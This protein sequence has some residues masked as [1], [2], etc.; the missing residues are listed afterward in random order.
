MKNLIIVGLLAILMLCLLT[1]E[2]VT[3]K[4]VSGT[5][6]PRSVVN[7]RQDERE[8][9]VQMVDGRL[10]NDPLGR[11]VFNGMWFEIDVEEYQYDHLTTYGELMEIYKWLESLKFDLENEED[12]TWIG[13]N[14]NKIILKAIGE[15]IIRNILNPG[16]TRWGGPTHGKM[17]EKV[18][19]LLAEAD[20][21]LYRF[22]S[23]GYVMY[24]FQENQIL[25]NIPIW[26][27]IDLA[28]QPDF[29]D[30]GGHMY[31][32]SAKLTIPTWN[33]QLKC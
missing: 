4:E 2:L 9:G 19:D 17:M 5:Q 22:Y 30:K 20:P 3:Y 24:K 6:V 10:F 14:F 29:D 16:K 12:M 32:R 18:F 7:T 25:T 26:A 28:M 15:N 23:L 8:S 27:L 31:V 33:I 13:D 1:C 21:D 11:L